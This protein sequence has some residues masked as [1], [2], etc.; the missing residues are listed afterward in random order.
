MAHMAQKPLG[1]TQKSVNL[2]TC[3]ENKDGV[4]IRHLNVLF[5]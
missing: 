4:E 2:S 1:A 3:T 5:L